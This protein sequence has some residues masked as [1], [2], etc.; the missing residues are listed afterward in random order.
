[1]PTWSPGASRPPTTPLGLKLKG[2][3]LQTLGN[4]NR[5][6]GFQLL[7]FDQPLG[8]EL[9]AREEVDGGD[10]AGQPVQ[11]LQCRLRD[12]LAGQLLAGDGTAVSAA[13]GVP[14]GTAFFTT[15]TVT[16]SSPCTARAV[17]A[18]RVA[19]HQDGSDDGQHQGRD[20]CQ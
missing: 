16:G 11:V 7:R 19:D 13:T 8:D 3:L 2:D 15:R 20:S 5:S 9:F 18:L 10:F 1:M 14:A 17:G 4:F 6:A 12:G